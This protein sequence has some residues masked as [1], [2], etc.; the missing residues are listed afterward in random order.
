MGIIK[1]VLQDDAGTGGANVAGLALHRVISPVQCRECWLPC[2]VAPVLVHQ[3]A[4]S[5]VGMRIMS[6]ALPLKI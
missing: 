1:L 5:S 2:I 6:F 4:G 3:E